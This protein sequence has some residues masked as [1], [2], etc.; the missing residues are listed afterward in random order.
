MT[1]VLAALVIAGACL[2]VAYRSDDYYLTRA[3][4][5]FGSAALIAALLFAV[6]GVDDVGTVLDGMVEQLPGE[7]A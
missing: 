2:A 7:H 3:A 5:V 1:A 4:G 6:F